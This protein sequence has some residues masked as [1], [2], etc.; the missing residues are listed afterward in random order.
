MCTYYLILPPCQIICTH[1]IIASAAGIRN[2]VISEKIDHSSIIS[3]SLLHQNSSRH[4]EWEADAVWLEH[5]KILSALA[6]MLHDIGKANDF[7]QWKLLITNIVAD[8]VRHEWI[9]SLFM[10]CL[11]RDL[12]SPWEN[13][14]QKAVTKAESYK[15]FSNERNGFRNALDA[16]LMLITTHHKLICEP[17]NSCYLTGGNHVRQRNRDKYGIGKTLAYDEY[18]GIINFPF[19]RIETLSTISF[20]TAKYC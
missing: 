2:L 18:K 16:L 12:S 6:G 10:E 17:K 19:S 7:F 4:P 1:L 8:P 9:S 20:L 15:P 11:S 5:A 3:V 14:W 13:I